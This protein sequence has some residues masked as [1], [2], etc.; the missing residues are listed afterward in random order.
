[1]KSLDPRARGGARPDTL[2]MESR[3]EGV[4]IHASAGGATFIF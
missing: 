2:Y 4:S 1:M 3:G